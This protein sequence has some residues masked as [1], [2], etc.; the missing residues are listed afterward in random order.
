MTDSACFVVWVQRS[1]GGIFGAA[2]HPV[3]QNGVL[4]AFNDEQDARCEC[5]RLNAYSGNP[6][7]SYT[8]ERREPDISNPDD[9]LDLTLDLALDLISDLAA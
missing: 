1:A 4:L 6:H 5:D 7:V 3:N 8:I 2:S 9:V